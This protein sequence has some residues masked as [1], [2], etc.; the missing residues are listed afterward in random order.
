MVD[1]YLSIKNDSTHVVSLNLETFLII[2]VI[3]LKLTIYC[4]K[5]LP[6]SMRIKRLN[7]QQECLII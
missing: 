5:I 6:V 7:G 4:L 2:F 1:R 3:V